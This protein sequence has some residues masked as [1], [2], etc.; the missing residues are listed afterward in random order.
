[1][2]WIELTALRIGVRYASDARRARITHACVRQR[3]RYS[4]GETAEHAVAAIPLSSAATA[5][6]LVASGKTFIQS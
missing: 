5:S 3:R 4:L 2:E 6:S 1:M